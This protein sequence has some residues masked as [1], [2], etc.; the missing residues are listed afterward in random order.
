MHVQLHLALGGPTFSLHMRG[1]RIW[2]NMGALSYPPV[3]AVVCA[4]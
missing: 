3:L 1:K 4:V 2:G